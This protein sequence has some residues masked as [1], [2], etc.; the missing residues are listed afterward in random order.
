MIDRYPMAAA[1]LC[2]RDG[3]LDAACY[4]AKKANEEE[5]DED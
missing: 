4:F 3:N 1:E 2:L 5:E